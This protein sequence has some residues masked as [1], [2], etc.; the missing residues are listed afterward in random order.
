M[1]AH[2]ADVLD[3]YRNIWCPDNDIRVDTRGVNRLFELF[4]KYNLRLAQPAIAGGEVSYQALRQRPGLVLRYSPYVE[5]MCPLFTREALSRA[6]TTFRESRSGW[7]LDWVW[8]RFFAP[9]E[10]AILDAVGVEHAGPLWRGENYQQ[11]AKLGVD[12]GQEFKQVV[13]RWGGF[14]PRLHRKFVRGKIKLPAIREPN[15]RLSRLARLA[16]GLGLNTSAA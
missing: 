4:E 13:D 1:L 5:V 15:A 6:A 3:R 10:I 7:G 2:H 16:A 9:Y 12:P 11:L 8:P 14:D